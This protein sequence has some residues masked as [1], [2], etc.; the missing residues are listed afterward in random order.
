MAC[1][2][3]Y[4]M[5]YAVFARETDP[6]IECVYI[7]RGNLPDWFVQQE[8]A[9]PILAVWMLESQR[10]QYLL[11]VEI[12]VPLESHTGAGGQVATRRVTAVEFI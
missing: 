2:K 10:T 5:Y 11:S 12:L 6:M 8:L 7:I 9:I 1:E 3:N 4:T